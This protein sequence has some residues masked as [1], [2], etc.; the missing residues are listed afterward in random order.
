[1]KSFI[2]VIPARLKS[3][4]LPNKLLLKI[5]GK[6]ILKYV[7]ERCNIAC[8]KNNIV[9]AT[10]DEKII[11]FCKQNSINFFKTSEKCLT[12]TD[13]VIEIAK[14]IKKDFYINVQGDEIF[15]SPESIKKIINKVRFYNSKY[16]VNAYT[17]IESDKEFRSLS[18]PKVV[19][20][21]NNY[22]LYISRGAIP[23]NKYNSKNKDSMKQVCIY[24]YPYKLLGK[25]PKNKK[26]KLEKYEDIEILRFIENGI[27]VKMIKAKG[28]KIAIDTISDYLKAKKLLTK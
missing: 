11:A 26:S 13:R 8:H 25:I 1:V 2:L 4:R 6:E 9:I 27:K 10:P 22:L 23:L 20:D 18:V 12:G 16:I 7:Y 28:S 21:K 15:V 5:N 17:K 3:T 19:M 24:G 14:K